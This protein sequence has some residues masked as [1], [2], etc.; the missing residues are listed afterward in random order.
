MRYLILILALFIFTSCGSRKRALEK[1]KEQSEASI[2]NETQTVITNDVTKQ[3]ETIQQQTE[4]QQEQEQEFS[5][6][7]ADTSKPASVQTET[8]DGKTIQTF[9]NFKNVSNSSKT[10]NKSNVNDTTVKQSESDKSKTDIKQKE[11]SQTKQAKES[12]SV[13]VE[14]KT[15]FPWWLLLIIALGASVYFYYSKVKNT[16]KPLNWFKKIV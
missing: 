1:T 11:E 8:K 14:R 13:Q 9:T 15:G 6:E 10:A 3:A 16:Y 4:L 7:V 5:G 2:K 12:K